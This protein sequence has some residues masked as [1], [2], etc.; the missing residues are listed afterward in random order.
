MVWAER[1]DHLI[2]RLIE[3]HADGTVDVRS[4]S[5]EGREATF[6]AA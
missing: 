6:D 1:Q 3:V 5:R 4:W 2:T